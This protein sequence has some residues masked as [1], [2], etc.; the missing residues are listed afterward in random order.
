L[1]RIG[2]DRIRIT[3]ATADHVNR[4]FVKR[5]HDENADIHT[6]GKNL[7]NKILTAIKLAITN[8]VV[9]RNLPVEDLHNPNDRMLDIQIGVNLATIDPQLEGW[10]SIKVLC[11][12]S[13]SQGTLTLRTIQKNF[14]IEVERDYESEPQIEEDYPEQDYP[15]YGD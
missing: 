5:L 8:G 13:T 4:T 11:R 6:Y 10:A 9:V 12:L 3:P 7:E 14:P 15:D 2:P 1:S